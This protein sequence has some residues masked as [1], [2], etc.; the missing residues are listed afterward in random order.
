MQNYSIYIYLISSFLISI[1]AIFFLIKNAHKLHLIDHPDYRK[2]HQDSTPTVGGLGII[3]TIFIVMF[4]SWLCN[5]HL[6]YLPLIDIYI[7]L[8]GSCIIICTGLIDD[9]KGLKA[10]EKFL[11]QLIASLV[12]V[13]GIHKF[14]TIN[15]PF[16]EFFNSTLYNSSLSVFY[17]IS[18]LNAINLIDGLDGLAG[19]V[20]IIFTITF[21]SL[22][23]LSGSPINELYLL[24]VLLGA[25][26][27]FI[28]FNRPP[29]KTFLGDT[30]S[31]FIG[32]LFAVYSLLYAQKTSFS[33]SILIPI[34]VLGLPA[35]DVLFV[36]FNR[37]NRRHNYKIKERLRS[38]FKADNY[39]IHHLIVSS[40]ISKTRAILLIYIFTC[41][42]SSVALY[43]FFNKENIDFRY[44]V[45]VVLVLTFFIRYLFS[46]KVKNNE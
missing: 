15:W 43:S 30:G 46:W 4:I 7:L 41:F 10:S 35:F 39:H 19:G 31:L 8:I 5:W 16:S 14:Q 23:L 37:F 13:L 33:L 38:I 28:F 17:I 20:S 2:F 26:V 25:L 22:S 12:V 40:G 34:I 24:F 27:G 9:I 6:L 21:I 44:S 42:T 32:W 3:L 18:I 36:M 45:I 1:L 11:F 29:A